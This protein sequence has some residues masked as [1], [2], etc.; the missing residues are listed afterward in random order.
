MKILNNWKLKKLAIDT[1]RGIK[2]QFTN[3]LRTFSLALIRVFEIHYEEN[4]I[5]TLWSRW[6][7]KIVMVC[8]CKK[9]GR[10]IYS[11]QWEVCGRLMYSWWVGKGL[12]DESNGLKRCWWLRVGGK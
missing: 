10:V 7:K 1:I 8:L 9:G 3:L 12:S 4:I 6:K 2:A 11:G 5:L